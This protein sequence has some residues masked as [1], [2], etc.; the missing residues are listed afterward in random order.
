MFPEAEYAARRDRYTALLDKLKQ[1]L[2][3]F[4]PEAKMKLARKLDRVRGS[5]RRAAQFSASGIHNPGSGGE[6]HATIETCAAF[7][8][9]T[10]SRDLQS[11]S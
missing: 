9:P 11:N 7:G 1:R 6:S 5:C 10:A 3:V 2:D 8:R 4:E